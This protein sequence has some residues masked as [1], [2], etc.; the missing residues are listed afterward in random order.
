VTRGAAA[1]RTLAALAL[2]ACGP[3]VEEGPIPAAEANT[4]ADTDVG[5]DVDTGS[6]TGTEA[7]IA[8]C[9]APPFGACPE[10]P[11]DAVPVLLA[12]EVED[13][14]VFVDADYETVL[15][16]RTVGGGAAPVVV[17]AAVNPEEPAPV[18]AFWRADLVGY[19]GATVEPIGITTNLQE[20]FDAGGARALVLARTPDGNALFRSDAHLGGDGTLA[21]FPGGEVPGDGEL[22]GLVYLRRKVIDTSPFEEDPRFN[23]VCAFGDG[24]YCF[25]G[26]GWQT[27]LPAG[28][29]PA[30][31]AVAVIDEG[32][33]AHVIAVGDDGR[34]VLETEGAWQELVLGPEVDLRAVGARGGRFTAAGGKG[35]V[36]DGTPEAQLVC[37]TYWTSL[38]SLNWVIGSAY[39]YGGDGVD[40]FGDLFVALAGDGAILHGAVGDGEG[41]MC[42]SGD[43]I[44][45]AILGRVLD[46]AYYVLTPGALWVRYYGSGA[47]VQ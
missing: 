47:V 4:G 22:R 33:E 19:D 13:G 11:D 42:D 16:R 28:S 21:A 34:A 20:P 30:L 46:V 23:R 8:T 44:P 40:D 15:A 35:V 24:L 3:G 36:V 6:D 32:D 10:S 2:A 5:T 29:G 39:G 41:M 43:A 7:D 25:D 45:G 27:E 37:Q 9:P 14:L 31:N 12:A 17:V 18:D 38:L 1:I 26:A